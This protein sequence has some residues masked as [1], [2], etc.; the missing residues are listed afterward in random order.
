MTKKIVH[1]CSEPNPILYNFAKMIDESEDLNNPYDHLF[2]LSERVKNNNFPEEEQ[3]K[4]KYI[5]FDFPNNQYLPK[6]MI[7]RLISLMSKKI[8]IYRKLF[9]GEKI[10]F[11][12]LPP[13]WLQLLI[14]LNAQHKNIHWA[15]FGGDLY[16][17]EKR[18][19]SLKNRLREL[20]RKKF[21][22]KIPFV[23]TRMEYA[24]LKNWYST[25]AVNIQ[26]S[27]PVLLDFK[28]MD[29]IKA[30]NNF[31]SLNKK[32]ILIG[33]SACPT[34]NHIEVFRAIARHIDSDTKVIVPLSY[35]VV[36]KKYLENVLET[37]K[38]IFGDLFEPIFDFMK[39]L[40]YIKF[41][42][43]VDMAIMNHDRQ[44]GLGLL[45]PLLYL[46]KKVY[47][48]STTTISNYLRNNLGCLIYDTED[49]FNDIKEEIFSYDES[50]LSNNPIK[51]KS[52]LSEE[53]VIKGWK[54]A[55]SL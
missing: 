17:Y 20:I 19:L 38:I 10:I 16:V 43:T 41:L 55:F 6:N 24:N 32:R 48:K 36:D 34:N 33:N 39:P 49:I 4:F 26:G 54:E 11:H 46:E 47:V 45:L 5:N 2:I 9:Q 29:K 21:I 3:I 44:R 51:I 42:N 40:D 22:K 18:N 52:A 8:E 23:H 31:N 13:T 35:S 50:R 53:E 7:N 12:S 1:Y 15:I 28:S 37:G 14:I 30:V 25:N 27:Y